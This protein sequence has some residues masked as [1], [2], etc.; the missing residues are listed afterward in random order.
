[1]AGLWPV[2][3]GDVAELVGTHWRAVR[4]Q[5]DFSAAV[6]SAQARA[7]RNEPPPA[8]VSPASA[9]I[10]DIVMRR[11][12]IALLLCAA[13]APLS[14]NE[15]ARQYA[16]QDVAA[17]TPD[18][19]RVCGYAIPDGDRVRQCLFDNQPS[20]STSCWNVIERY[21]LAAREKNGRA[22]RAT[23]GQGGQS[24]RTRY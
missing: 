9:T 8:F 6:A 20:L 24:T 21:R 18:A 16:P 13:A 12:G 1:M 2:D 7:R 5:R 10:E 4:P 22:P 15:Y 3:H 17:C 19:F 14:A 23:T 11:L